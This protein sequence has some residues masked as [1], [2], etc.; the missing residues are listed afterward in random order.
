MFIYLYYIGNKVN[1]YKFVCSFIFCTKNN[2]KFLEETFTFFSQTLFYFIFNFISGI[3]SFHSSIIIFAS[4]S[5][6]SM[7]FLLLLDICFVFRQTFMHCSTQ[8]IELRHTK[9]RVIHLLFPRCRHTQKEV[10]FL[11]NWKLWISNQIICLILL[12]LC[13]CCVENFVNHL[14]DYGNCV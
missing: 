12:S 9:T 8:T 1:S 13:R 10:F 4:N 3:Y 2:T 5:F 14:F 11:F 6:L 7:I